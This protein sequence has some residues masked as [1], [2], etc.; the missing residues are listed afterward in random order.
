M[1]RSLSWFFTLLFL[2]AAIGPHL[3]QDRFPRPEFESAY[4]RPLTTTPGP[5]G[6]I[7]E[8]LDVVLL[9]T[10][11]GLTSFFALKKRSRRA[12]FWLTVFSALYFGFYRNGCVCAVGSIQNVS[13]ALFYPGYV[14]PLGVVAFFVLPLIF[15]LFFGRTFCAA[16]CPLGA[17][18]DLVM[19]K[20][21]KV[22][23]WLS[24]VLSVVPYLYLGFGVLFAA[25]GASFIICKYDPFISIYRMS[26]NFGA[27]LYSAGFVGLC[28]FVGRPY[29]R[30]LCPYGVLLGWLSTLSRKHVTITPDECVVCRLCED[31]CDFGHIQK[32][33]VGKIP[34]PR[35]QST[36]R[37]SRLVLLIP[38]MMVAGGW[39]LSQMD[40]IFARVHPQVQ[41]AEEIVLEDAGLLSETTLE[42]RTFRTAGTPT[43]ELLDEALAIQKKF[44]F[45]GWLLGGFLGL[46]FGIKLI[47]LAVL[48]QRAEYE[49]DNTGCF[50][51]SRCFM[52]CPNEHV[53][54]GHID[55][56]WV[57]NLEEHASKR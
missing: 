47:R 25:T 42:T 14:M 21:V 9:A 15:A 49:I 12:I 39:A 11:L 8:L 16:V 56:D 7:L 51:C 43:Q 32:P 17:M 4:Q 35:A 40:V 5:A 36:K 55:K 30:F 29:C 57:L 20:P 6:R 37:L 1:K 19:L 34:E 13:A 44:Y 50:S 24:E 23:S 31:G 2:A 27:M 41:L 18:Q 46:V 53:R 45:G 54:L 28:V 33:V 52:S 10:A 48:P 3:A 38:V 22:P 26:D